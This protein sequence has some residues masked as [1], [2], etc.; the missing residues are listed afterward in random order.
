MFR[1][2]KNKINT[3]KRRKKRKP[4]AKV[5]VNYSAKGNK[6]RINISKLSNFIVLFLVVVVF[7]FLIYFIAQLIIK[8]NNLQ[9]TKAY[10]DDLELTSWTAK[11]RLYLLVI[12]MDERE[13]EYG[14]S[15]NLSLIMI[16]PASKI[17]GVYIINVDTFVFDKNTNKFTNLRNLY[18][19]NL[20]DHSEKAPVFALQDAIENLL[21][22]KIDRYILIKEQG[23]EKLINSLGG[24]FVDNTS[25]VVDKEIT[26][27][28]ISK[29]NVKLNGEDALNYVRVDDDGSIN[30]INRQ[31]K[32]IEAISNKM[33]SFSIFFRIPNVL[34][35]F[36][37]DI[38]TNFSKKELYLLGRNLA[39]VK[40]FRSGYMGSASIYK[41]IYD[42]KEVYYPV[43]EDIDASIGEIFADIEIKKE[44]ARVEVFNSTNI[45]G[46]A[47][48][49]SR[50]MKNF[51]IDVIRTGDT[52]DVH[53]K[54]TLYITSDEEYKNTIESIKALFLEE[55]EI[56]KK[57][58]EFTHTGDI[59]FVVGVNAKFE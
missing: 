40:E 45:K 35:F 49:R 42:D 18:N 9:L 39:Q 10:R 38:K 59:V 6:K 22:V 33:T 54:S 7:V 25:E 21:A 17:M 13:G 48:I 5:Y 50:M 2:I 58:P 19:L 43:I 34:D 29:G 15:D 32:S 26:G 51:G 52:R 27:Y 56:V 53:E 3:L 16:D 46:I 41:A 8:Y 37:S 23:Y 55:I 31:I 24:V 44:Q 28:F 14:F 11:E 1:L 36:E 30:K 20:V 12:G 57:S 47:S 4:K